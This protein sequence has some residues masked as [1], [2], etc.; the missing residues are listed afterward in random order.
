MEPCPPLVSGRER[1]RNWIW[2][3]PPLC[4]LD[5]STAKVTMSGFR[6]KHAIM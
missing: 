5:L 6:N 1:V 4:N 2:E 3:N